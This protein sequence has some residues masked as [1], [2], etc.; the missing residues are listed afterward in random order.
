MELG[1]QMNLFQV[2]Q[3]FVCF[4]DSRLIEANELS[5][6]QALP[7]FIMLL[8]RYYCHTRLLRF[9]CSNYESTWFRHNASV[10]FSPLIGLLAPASDGVRIKLVWCAMRWSIGNVTDCSTNYP[11]IHQ[12]NILSMITV[13]MQKY[14]RPVLKFWAIDKFLCNFAH[15]LT[16][17]SAT[18][19]C[20][21]LR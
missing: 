14:T 4:L 18:W 20:E 21:P 6:P 5:A 9:L 10:V 2:E 15:A 3:L 7:W 19:L 11:Q 1:C 12:T 16:Q 17:W 13:K 8:C